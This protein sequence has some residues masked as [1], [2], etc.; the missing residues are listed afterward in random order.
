[1]R[2]TRRLIVSLLAIAAFGVALG[3]TATPALAANPCSGSSWIYPN[4][5]S[6]GYFFYG[7]DVNCGFDNIKTYRI[8][9][10]LYYASS[11]AQV[12]NS[13]RTDSG[14]ARYGTRAVSSIGDTDYL[15]G[16]VVYAQGSWFITFY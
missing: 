13:C 8:T 11:H 12:A 1:M 15:P 6:S 9:T 7:S 5:P 2:L 16:Q 14:T 10:C 3:A 4:D